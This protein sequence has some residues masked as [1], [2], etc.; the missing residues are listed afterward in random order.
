LHMSKI[1]SLYIINEHGDMFTSD[2][3]HTL[4]RLEGDSPA[5]LVWFGVCIVCL[6]EKR[7]KNTK[8]IQKQ[9]SHN[10]M[11]NI[12]KLFTYQEYCCF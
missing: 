3:G 7:Q 11:Y 2:D 4:Y 8:K 1:R 5:P 6:Q 10:T 9:Q 12:N